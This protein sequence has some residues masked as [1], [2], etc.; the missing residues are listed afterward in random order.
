MILVE[1]PP[2]RSNEIIGDIGMPHIS[3]VFI[4]THKPSRFDDVPR[5]IYQRFKGKRAFGFRVY[6]DGKYKGAGSSWIKTHEPVVAQAAALDSF[7]AAIGGYDALTDIQIFARTAYLRA[8][9]DMTGERLLKKQQK[10]SVP[11]WK[12]EDLWENLALGLHPYKWGIRQA[13]SDDEKAELEII[14][15]ALKK[16]FYSGV[17]FSDA[18]PPAPDFVLADN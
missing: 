14:E 1:F 13:I 15:A 17:R 7:L 4:S 6:L 11:P 9:L 16:E 8:K 2:K 5:E 10:I 18:V 3:K 12:H